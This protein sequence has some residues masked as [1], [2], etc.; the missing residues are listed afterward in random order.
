M[1]IGRS[2]GALLIP[3]I[4]P[5]TSDT[6]RL[7]QRVSRSPVARRHANALSSKAAQIP[8]ALRHH[9][10]RIAT[11]SAQTLEANMPHDTTN[12]PAHQP[13]AAFTASMF[14]ALPTKAAQIP[15]ALRHH[16]RTLA[17]LLAP[18][19]QGPFPHYFCTTNW[20]LLSPAPK[21]SFPYHICATNWPLLSPSLKGPRHF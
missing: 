1:L 15:M 19:L 18:A 8:M 2:C 20:P 4:I 6:P 11:R 21:R 16:E 5:L 14:C 12:H 13:H 7:R 10:R 9:E 3:Q 17:T